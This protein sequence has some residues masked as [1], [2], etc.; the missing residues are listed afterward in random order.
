MTEELS[1]RS[2]HIRFGIRYLPFIPR[3]NWD[4]SILTRGIVGSARAKGALVDEKLYTTHIDLVRGLSMQPALQRWPVRS[5]GVVIALSN[6]VAD[7]LAT[8]NLGRSTLRTVPSF[9][10]KGDRE[11]ND[12][13]L[14]EPMEQNR[15][16]VATREDEFCKLDSLGVGSH[17]A[18]KPW[19]FSGFESLT[20]PCRRVDTDLDLWVDPAWRGSL[21]LSRKLIRI[22]E[23]AGMEQY[24]H[25]TRC[26]VATDAEIDED[27]S[28][29]IV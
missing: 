12:V 2:S 6:E 20:L 18:S 14:L 13:C 16:I 25:T 19:D 3:G 17:P 5:N 23:S 27:L 1:F 24:W 22:L 15:T 7:V 29:D 21:F 26:R 8:A 4:N 10:F 11:P 9:D 28:R